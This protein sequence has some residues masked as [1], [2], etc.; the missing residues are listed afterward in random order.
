MLSLLRRGVLSLAA[1]SLVASSVSAEV[2][3]KLR[4]VPD[5]V[6]ELRLFTKD[7]ANCT[8][9]AGNTHTTQMATSRY[10]SKSPCNNTMP[11]ASSN[12]Y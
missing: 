2:F 5:G 6:T 1:V 12:A 8:G 9:Q 4:S 10:G 3:E 11:T 7:E